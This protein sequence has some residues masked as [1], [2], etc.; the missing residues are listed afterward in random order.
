MVTRLLVEIWKRVV[1]Q[2]YAERLVE[3]LAMFTL[4]EAGVDVQGAQSAGKIIH[5]SDV[6]VSF[7]ELYHNPRATIF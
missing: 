2:A 1:G 5:K 4:L 7:C 6:L 3:L